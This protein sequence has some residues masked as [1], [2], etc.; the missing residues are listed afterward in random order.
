MSNI[1]AIIFDLDNTLLWDERSIDEAFEATC[2]KASAALTLQPEALESAVRECAEKLFSEMD[3]FEWAN[4]LEVTY[5][6]ALWGRFERGENPSF[7]KLHQWAPIYQRESWISG[8]RKLGIDEPA[9]GAVLAEYFAAERRKRPLVYDDTFRILDLLK[10]HYPLLLLTN[11]APD[12][13]QEK[14]DSIPHLAGYFDHIIIS[15]TFGAGK[16]SPSIFEHALKLLG[17]APNEA[18]MIGD[19]LN[20]D[21]KG[22]NLVGM[23]NIWI[24]HAQRTAPLDN[25][26]TYEVKNLSGLLPILQPTLSL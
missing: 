12:L 6:E 15:G 24:N 2:L 26:P 8:L 11:G 16:P 4:M 10:P 17:L 18:M 20:T 5:L 22:A 1:K 25:Q 14:I 21:I 3:M 19:N 23:P 9:F 7:N 13:Q